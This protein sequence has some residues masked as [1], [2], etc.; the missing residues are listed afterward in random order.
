MRHVR[1]HTPPAPHTCLGID[2][3][4]VAA[5]LAGS[6]GDAEGPEFAGEVLE[7]L[8]QAHMLNSA[9][10]AAA[11]WEWRMRTPAYRAMQEAESVAAAAK[12]G[13]AGKAKE[14]PRGA[15]KVTAKALQRAH[16]AGAS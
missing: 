3:Q 1:M 7:W 6:H 10:A 11:L 12:A 13:K 5:G 2:P 4:V 16:A 9:E 15:P 14:P 8:R